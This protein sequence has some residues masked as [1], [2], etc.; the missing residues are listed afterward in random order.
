[1]QGWMGHE[2]EASVLCPLGLRRAVQWA[3][4]H[5][6][7]GHSWACCWGGGGGEARLKSVR[8]TTGILS[9]RPCGPVWLIFYEQRMGTWR[10]VPGLTQVNR[11]TGTACLSPQGRDVVP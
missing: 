3:L 9:S 7:A 5:R 8:L 2:Q 1:M 6:R 4:A 11:G 10:S